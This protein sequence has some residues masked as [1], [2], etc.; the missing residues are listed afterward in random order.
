MEKYV[1]GSYQSISDSDVM[2]VWTSKISALKD[3]ASGFV[4]GISD[5]SPDSLVGIATFY[6][7]G[8]GWNSSTEGKLNHGLSKVNKNEML[9]SVNALLRTAVPLHRKDWSMHTANCRR[10]KMA[11]KNM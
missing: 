7:I 1:D 9:K 3:A 2:A 8:N 4:T 11:T 10:Q 5:T 6:G